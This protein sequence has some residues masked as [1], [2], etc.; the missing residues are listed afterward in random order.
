MSSRGAASESHAAELERVHERIKNKM[1]ASTELCHQALSIK[2]ISLSE[3]FLSSSVTPGGGGSSTLIQTTETAFPR[4][5]GILFVR[6]WKIRL[7][8]DDNSLDETE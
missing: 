7:P 3:A 2:I 5:V 4:K 8:T 6:D 1:H